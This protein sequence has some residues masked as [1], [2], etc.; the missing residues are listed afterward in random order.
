M[1]ENN[2]KDFEEDIYKDAPGL[3]TDL[4]WEEEAYYLDLIYKSID[5]ELCDST[6][7]TDNGLEIKNG[8]LLHYHGNE[9]EVVIP[10]SI[11]E[12]RA[13]EENTVIFSAF[14]H[15]KSLK[16][17]VIP[18]SV[19]KIG[20]GVFIGCEN[21]ESIVVDSN[22]SVYHSNDNCLIETETKTLIAGCKNSI[23]PADGSVT[24]IADAAFAKC[25]W[26]EN[27]VIPQ[28]VRSIGWEAFDMCESLTSIVLPES[29]T[30]IEDQAFA[31][32]KVMKKLVLSDAITFIGKEAFLR[33]AKLTSA[34]PKGGAK[35]KFGLEF[36][37]TEKIP[38]NAFSGLRNLKKVILPETVKEIGKNAFKS[39]KNLEEI[40]FNAGIKCDKKLFKDCVKLSVGE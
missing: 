32:C 38:E 14:S 5:D 39:C 21:L 28:S 17:V 19:M 22:N 31:D 25:T 29:V 27:I 24:A 15:C 23:I 3:D 18:A 34:G 10:D 6:E 37:W 36:P 16:H 11:T 26:L 33:C 8:V 1:S 40:N 20:R 35:N 30:T 9:T 7:I 4:E 13:Y 12:I 2:K